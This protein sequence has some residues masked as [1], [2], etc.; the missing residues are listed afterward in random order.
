MNR[1]FNTPF[2]MEL[3]ILMLL[4]HSPFDS[5][6]RDQLVCYDFICCYG[7]DYG[8]TDFNLHGDSSYKFGEIASRK[9]LV[10]MA[11]K[12]LVL[13]GLINAVMDKGFKYEINDN[14]IRYINSL[15]NTY[16]DNYMKAAEEA[17][18]KY[19]LS[20][21]NAAQAFIIDLT[22]KGGYTN[23]QD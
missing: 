14:G 22:R 17:F 1:F 13:S 20:E 11:I 5:L 3:R 18:E 16:G 7:K 10:D 9:E 21:D 23:V 4:M 6:N 12:E 2:E 8:V 19:D 15:D